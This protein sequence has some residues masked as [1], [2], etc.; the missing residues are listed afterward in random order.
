M[1]AEDPQNGISQCHSRDWTLIGPVIRSQATRNCERNFCKY[2]F[3]SQSPGLEPATSGL[4]GQRSVASTAAAYESC[5]TA[6]RLQPKLSFA[7]GVR[8]SYPILPSTSSVLCRPDMA[9]RGHC[10][11]S[12]IALRSVFRSS[13]P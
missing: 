11:I 3:T 8:K 9:S 10:P 4:T 12:M 6:F 13:C 2:V 7:D 5:L 1:A